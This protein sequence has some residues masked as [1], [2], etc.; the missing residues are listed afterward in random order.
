[1]GLFLPFQHCRRSPRLT[2][3]YGHFN[4]PHVGTSLS[5][6]ALRTATRDGADIAVQSTHKTL[7]GLTQAAMLHASG[8]LVSPTRIAAA[9]RSLQVRLTAM[10]RSAAVDVQPMA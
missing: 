8:P 4:S 5:Q 1:M 6:P 3:Q 2:A 10:P 9:L 7:G